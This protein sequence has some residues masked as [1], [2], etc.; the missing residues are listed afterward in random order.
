[1][2]LEA[3]RETLNA[4]PFQPFTIH[5]ADGRSIP[6]VSREFIMRDPRGRTVYVH[7]P[8]NGLS[9]IDL[10]LVTELETH[11]TGENGRKRRRRS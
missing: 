8:D 7:H 3:F 4:Q 2:T 5:T 11:S 6:V 1:M 10:L 9:K